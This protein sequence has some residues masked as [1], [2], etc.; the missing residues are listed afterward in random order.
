MKPEDGYI[1]F[2]IHPKSGAGPGKR[3]GWQFKQYLS[4]AG[5]EVRV[6]LTAGLND[7][8]EAATDAAVDFN[9]G[10]VVAAG[11]DGTVREVAHGLEGSDKPLLIVPCGTE[12]LLANELG[13]DRKVETVI[14]AFRDFDIKP[15]DLG[16]A[17]GR[18]F[19][20]ITGIGFDGRVVHNVAAQRK[21]HI[22]YSDYF[23]P[24]W[25]T[26]WGYDFAAVQVEVDGKQVFEGN[27]L[28]FIGNISRYAIGLQILHYADY[29]D[30]LLDLCIYKCVSKSRLVKHSFKTVL[31]RHFN[32][33][34]VIYKQGREFKV[35]SADK[36]M[37]TEIDGDPGPDLPLNI[38]VIPEA[39][40][41]VMPSDAKPA[42]IRARLIRR[43][44]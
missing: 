34:D 21:G 19:T 39:V 3:I 5:Y 27:G 12:N 18:C 42:G 24:L 7:A 36:T 1:T 14:R 29:S 28:V 11:G 26:Y 25:R 17:N 44:K 16:T 35:H 30:G 32:S 43:L 15:L 22:D 9:C 13:I 8:C 41:V 10:L 6:S 2:I 40:N 20:S 37:Q 23:W 33:S 31:K 4:R 38:K